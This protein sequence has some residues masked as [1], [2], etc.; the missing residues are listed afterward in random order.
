MDL[1]HSNIK[2]LKGIGLTRAE[3]IFREIGVSTY[4]DLLHHYP[5]SYVDR[6]KVYRII[7]F[8][9]D[10]P[11]VQ[12]R[13]HFVS[14]TIQGEGAKMRLVGLFTDGTRTMEIVWFRNIRTLRTAYHLGAIYVVFGKPVLF[15]NRWTMS[16]PE[17]DP[18][19]SR[20]SESGLRGV[21]PLTEGLRKRNISSRT[22]FTWVCSVLDSAGYIP[23][24]LPPET[25][26]QYNLMSKHDALHCIHR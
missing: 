23:E 18:E 7:D 25:V 10:M 19:G 3:V 6:S 2:F 9:G 1:R 12:V 22:I 20:L 13:G 26:Q 5:N 21:Y 14:L 16:H 4:H 8:S 15:N 17:I 24:T 11:C